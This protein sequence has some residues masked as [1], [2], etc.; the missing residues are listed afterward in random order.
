MSDTN[1]T[2]QVQFTFTMPMPIKYLLSD[3]YESSYQIEHGIYEYLCINEANNEGAF[4]IPEMDWILEPNGELLIQSMCEQ[5]VTFTDY[6]DITDRAAAE[7]VIRKYILDIVNEFPGY[8]NYV[9]VDNIN[10]LDIEWI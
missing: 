6:N 10:I 7:K 8:N 9:S 2:E 3:D 5:P 4:D 1:M